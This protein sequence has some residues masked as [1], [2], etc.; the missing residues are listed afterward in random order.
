MTARAKAEKLTAADLD[1]LQDA[2]E[3]R[4]VD[5]QRSIF[6][7]G[8]T[9]WKIKRELAVLGG[10]GCALLLQVAHPLVAAGVARYSNYKREPL[11]RLYRTLDLMLTI[12]F[13]NAAD[14]LRA[15]RQIERRHAKVKGQLPESVGTYP[16]GTPYDA[17]AP[18]LQL[19][20]HATL[21]D[22]APRLYEM[23]VGRLS[24]EEHHTYHEESKVVGRLLGIPR[25]L[26]PKTAKQFA[27]YMRS[28]IASD[29]LAVGAAG[30][31][32][33]ESILAPSTP[34]GLKYFL[35]PLNLLTIGLLPEPVRRLYGYEWSVWQE[36]LLRGMVTAT[37]LAI[38]LLPAALRY[39]PQARQ[40]LSRESGD[41]SGWFEQRIQA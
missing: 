36:H 13:S 22:T 4:T 8:T 35:P 15:V 29:A 26:L 28:M 30:R 20:V 7:P 5:L 6:G 3:R 11:Q 33:A 41:S 31:D 25:D 9:T 1:R 16:R 23:F 39:F 32:I 12:T 10:G 40:A 37:E 2:C 19:W 24:A 18:D 21:V 17:N 38:P 27:E 14:A 34:F